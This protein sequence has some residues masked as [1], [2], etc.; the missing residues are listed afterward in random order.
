MNPL[1]EKDHVGLPVAIDVDDGRLKVTD[2]FAR[3]ADRR[4]LGW[5]G[6]GVGW[7]DVE[8]LKR[9]LWPVV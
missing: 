3:V 9:A 5:A 7:N 4:H 1:F 8:L 2:R 6:L